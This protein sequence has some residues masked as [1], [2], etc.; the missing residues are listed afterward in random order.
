[1]ET[2][3]PLAVTAAIVLGLAWRLERRRGADAERQAGR[4]ARE[5]GD[6]A[7]QWK[8]QAATMEAATSASVDLLLAADT[9]L[10]VLYA[11][12][13]ARTLFGTP[14]GME[15]LV[16]YTGSPQTGELARDALSVGETEGIERIVQLA[17][18]PYRARATRTAF[19]VGV[20]LQDVSELQRLTQARQDLIDN[21][22]HELRTPLSALRLLADTLQAPAGQDPEI[23]RQLAARMIEEVET[24]Q[25]MT[26]EM[27]DLSAIES[28]RQ[29]VR[30]FPHNLREVVR[31]VLDRMGPEIA[32]RGVQ[33]VVDMSEE[34]KILAD[35]EPAA[36]AVQ[37]VIHNAQ[38]FSPPGG[39]IRIQ[40]RRDA[41]Q[42]VLSIMD[43]GPG[44]ASADLERIF[45][46]FYR[47]DRARGTPGTGLGLAIAHHIL[48]AHGGRI[49]AENRRPP[50]HGAI[51]H[52][53]FPAA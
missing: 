2:L 21:L 35:P 12:P 15:T 51:F 37:N 18:R 49:W 6:Q 46:R 34:L 45:E 14:L 53:A 27:L 5:Q 48:R 44:M 8:A 7:A 33:L 17:A 25:Q 29:V 3:L 10:T 42:V 20:W 43:E 11:N 24:L 16:T 41:E 26:Q 32:R 47:G 23:A 4:V 22:S 19:G 13:A 31:P 52:L 36:R 40:G 50:D 1:V 39:E 38:K 30:L 28:G 9:S